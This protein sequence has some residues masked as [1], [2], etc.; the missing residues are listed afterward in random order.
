MI[1]LLF[2]LDWLEPAS[3]RASDGY[4]STEM[5]SK[6]VVSNSET[7]VLD[8]KR[9]FRSPN[10]RF[11]FKTVVLES[12]NDCFGVQNDCFGFRRGTKT[13]AYEKDYLMKAKA[14]GLYTDSFSA[15]FTVAVMFPMMVAAAFCYS[16]LLMLVLPLVIDWSVYRSFDRWFDLLIDR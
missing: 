14:C 5:Q 2:N 3:Q 9:S 16:Y 10:N 12:E 1:F 8:P 6:T 15:K 7:V 13:N 11:G 4:E